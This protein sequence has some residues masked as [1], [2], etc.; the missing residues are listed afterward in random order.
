MLENKVY[1][2][3][4]LIPKNYQDYLE[5]LF[6]SSLPW[7]AN[8]LIQTTTYKDKESY[9]YFISSNNPIQEQIFET[10]QFI[11]QF[12]D[13]DS[14]IFSPHFLEIT[15]LIHYIQDYFK[16][17]YKVTPK[18]IKAN[19]KHQIPP[20]YT[21]KINTPHVDYHDESNDLFTIIY[22]VNDSDGDTIL[23]NEYYEGYPISTFSQQKQIT[24]KKGKLVMFPSKLF[25]SGNFPVLSPFRSVINLNVNFFK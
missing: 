11:H 7:Y 21:S 19:F 14:D 15:P 13:V 3:E 5:V 20:E 4:D 10:Y 24:P 1:I 8:N 22:Y 2:F 23:F 16:Y 6:L 25:H 18:R 12:I 17:E 9:D